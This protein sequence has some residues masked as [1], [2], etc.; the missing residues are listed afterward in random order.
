MSQLKAEKKRSDRLL[1][2]MLPVEVARQLRQ[3]RQVSDNV[4]IVKVFAWGVAISCTTS[5]QYKDNFLLRFYSHYFVNK[6]RKYEI[7]L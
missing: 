3:N 5:S 2:Q 7:G 4:M 1:Y 6:L